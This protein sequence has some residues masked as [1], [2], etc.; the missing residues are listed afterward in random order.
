MYIGSADL[1]TRNTEAAGGDRLPGAGSRHP[2]QI[3]RA[4]GIYQA[5]NVKAR[6]LRPDGSYSRV[7]RQ[8]GAP[9]VDAQPPSWSRRWKRHPRPL[10]R[11]RPLPSAGPACLPGSSAGAG[12]KKKSR[13]LQQGRP[14]K[15]GRHGQG[16]M[17][18]RFL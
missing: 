10:L 11:P 16:A 18:S 2:G 8:E 17:P 1:M 14:E 13:P 9:A 12:S 15:A 7:E 6:V 4:I 3:L 5:D